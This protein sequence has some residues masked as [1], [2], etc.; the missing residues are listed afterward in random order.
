[1]RCTGIWD[2]TGIDSDAGVDI[3]QMGYKIVISVYSLDRRT[4]L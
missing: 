1:M 2:C 3:L 4:R